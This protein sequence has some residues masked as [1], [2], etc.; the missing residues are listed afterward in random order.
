MGSPPPP[1][2]NDTHVVLI[3][4]NNDPKSIFDY[5]PISLCNVIF[6]LAYKVIANR[7]KKILPSIVSDTQS[8][9]FVHGRLITNNILVAFEVMHHISQKKASKKGT[10]VLKLDMSKHMT[11]WSGFVL[12]KSWRS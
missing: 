7:L 4:K 8:A 6:K 3:P 5:R 1:K 11:V 2:F 9:A 12:K 10:M